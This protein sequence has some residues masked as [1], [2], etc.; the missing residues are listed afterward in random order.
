M[1]TLA[2][3]K[4]GDQFL[5][6]C[7]VV[8]K[9]VN[10]L[11]LALYGPGRVQAATAL[12]APTGAMTGSLSAT[13]DQVPVTIVT[14]FVPVSVGDVL[15]NSVSGETAVCRWSQINKDGTVVWSSSASSR[16]IYPSSGWVV[17]SHVTL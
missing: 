3:L 10:G 1:T 8:S 14:G 5:F 16:V 12:I 9:D 6:A 2:D 11:G 17:I 15:E 4:T 7:Q 13:P